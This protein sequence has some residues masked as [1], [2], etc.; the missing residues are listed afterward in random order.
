MF[1]EPQD[2]PQM[3]QYDDEAAVS[4]K[5]ISLYYPVSPL[6]NY[7]IAPHLDLRLEFHH[8]LT[9]YYLNPHLSLL[10]F[11][12]HFTPILHRLFH[13]L[14]NPL[15]HLTIHQR[16]IVPLIFRLHFYLFLFHHYL[17]ILINLKS[18]FNLYLL[19]FINF[20]I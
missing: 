9:H 17:I 16:L 15:K 6:I 18:L 5:L 7:L 2:Y 13:H 4:F 12:M 3:H 19:R 1:S 8:L 14:T 11:H 10:R 20:M